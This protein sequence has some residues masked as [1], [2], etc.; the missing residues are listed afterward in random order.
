MTPVGARRGQGVR[1]VRPQNHSANGEKHC[2]GATTGRDRK[3]RTR[4]PRQNT[5][6]QRKLIDGVIGK[7]LVLL[8][9]KASHG[10]FRY[11]TSKFEGGQTRFAGACRSG[12]GFGPTTH[13]RKPR[14]KTP[15]AE[16][17]APEQPHNHGTTICQVPP[18]KLGESRVSNLP[19]SPFMNQTATSVV[20]EF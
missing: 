18:G 15:R 20:A 8:S 16:R 13:Q 3:P 1:P 11:S 14:C 17:L 12:L 10:G 6:R 9:H 4:Q 5:D 19:C 2:Q 7:R